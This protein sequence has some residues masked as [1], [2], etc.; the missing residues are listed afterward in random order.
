MP[1]LPPLP[2][3]PFIADSS[4][5]GATQGPCDLSCWGCSGG[6]SGCSGGCC[7]KCCCCCCCCLDCRGRRCCR[8][9]S[10]VRSMMP[11]ITLR[12]RRTMSLASCSRFTAGSVF[13]L[14]GCSRLARLFAA[15]VPHLDCVLGLGGFVSRKLRI[16]TQACTRSNMSSKSPRSTSSLFVAGVHGTLSLVSSLHFRGALCCCPVRLRGVLSLA[17][18]LRFAL[19]LF[20]T[21]LPLLRMVALRCFAGDCFRASFC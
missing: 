4:A 2:P 6:C 13:G 14:P 17:S 18:S 9:S 1:A 15:S 16:C 5:P 20:S 10:S 11:W 19:G 21:R 12:P 3:L 8:H 7:W